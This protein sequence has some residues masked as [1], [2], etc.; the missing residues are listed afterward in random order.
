MIIDVCIYTY[1]FFYILENVYLRLSGLSFITIPWLPRTHGISMP[2]WCTN[3][4]TYIPWS[5]VTLRW[6]VQTCDT[7]DRLD[8]WVMVMGGF[9][10]WVVYDCFTH[11]NW[12]F[13]GMLWIILDEL[14]SGQRLHSELERS[15][16]LLMGK[17]TI[18][19][20]I[21]NSKLLNYQRVVMFYWLQGLHCYAFL[22][23]RLPVMSWKRA[24]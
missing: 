19:M 18:S 8:R 11:M 22:E 7:M 3:A 6:G 12:I 16:M 10:S 24:P 23:I 17:S 9:Q 14:P 4:L 2:I 21:F 13:M 20:A 5:Y 1:I 15:T